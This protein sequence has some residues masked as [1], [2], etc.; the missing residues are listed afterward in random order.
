MALTLRQ[1]V[2]FIGRTAQEHAH[3]IGEV[4]KDSFLASN[5]DETGKTILR[6][7]RIGNRQRELPASAFRWHRP[8]VASKLIFDTEHDVLIDDETV[9]VKVHAEYEA[10]GKQ[11]EGISLLHEQLINEHHHVDVGDNKGVTNG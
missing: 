11:P 3:A 2:D 8:L 6:K 4:G 1:L 9:R 5:Q 7:F 10:T